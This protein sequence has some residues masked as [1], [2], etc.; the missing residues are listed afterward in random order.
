MKKQ[1]DLNH[2]SMSS[3]E[4]A[5]HANEGTRAAGQPHA[6]IDSSALAN[7]NGPSD[8]NMQSDSDEINQQPLQIDVPEIPS[9]SQNQS[10]LDNKLT[11]AG[12]NNN[13]QHKLTESNL[14]LKN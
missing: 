9:F 11:F 8:L 5:S 12:L 13:I 2:V 7:A 1:I 14:S 10:Q 3:I 6:S 4:P